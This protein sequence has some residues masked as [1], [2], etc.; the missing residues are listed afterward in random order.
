MGIIYYYYFASR[1]APVAPRVRPP[2]VTPPAPTPPPIALSDNTCVSC[3]CG[4]TVTVGHTFADWEGSSHARAGVAVCAA[5]P[6]KGQL[7]T[8]DSLNVGEAVL[9]LPKGKEDIEQNIVLIVRL[10]PEQLGAPTRLEWTAE[11][12]VAYSAI[13]THLG[14][15][16]LE[17][18]RAG[19]IFCP[20]HAG[21][22]DP[23]RGAIVVSGPPR[24]GTPEVKPDWY[25]LW[26]YGLLK[27][28]P[29]WMETHFLGTV[30]TPENIGG[31][32]LPGLLGLVLILWPFL[33]RARQPTH[34]LEPPT[35][36]RI[37]WGLGFLVLIGI[38]ASAGYADAL[39]LSQDWLRTVA[40]GGP[41]WVGLLAYLLR[42]TRV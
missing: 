32:L 38:L 41:I 27:L 21:V 39:R 33:D 14:C 23:G 35:P 7:L 24:P 11:G 16:V 2:T 12:F 8:R 1:Q 13:C 29:S 10:A 31:V 15:T 19:A 40:V 34:Y 22:F 18:L 3:H 25:F 6:R 9:A 37:A 26:G 36:R 28:I 17:G 30:I 4:L 5:G 42:K 20:C